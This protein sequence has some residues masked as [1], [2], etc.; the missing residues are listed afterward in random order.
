MTV[1]SING[2][3]ACASTAA[4]LDPSITVARTGEN[5]LLLNLPR[6]IEDID[7]ATADTS[8]MSR[9]TRFFA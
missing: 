5:T 8:L 9:I 2:P 1:R 3:A 7:K 6:N 4:K